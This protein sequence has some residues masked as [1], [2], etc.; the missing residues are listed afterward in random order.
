MNRFLQFLSLTKRSGSLV[1]GYNNCYSILNKKNI[2]LFVFSKE[3][4]PNSEK[5][6]KSYC[7][8]KNIP[9]IKE[10]TKHELGTS[11]GRKEIN[12]VCVTD[13]NLSNKLLSL[14]EEQNTQTKN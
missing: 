11:L 2:F 7:K 13:K 4:S 3:L 9:Y 14:L 12:I 5:K 6:F 1:E 8:L 10:F